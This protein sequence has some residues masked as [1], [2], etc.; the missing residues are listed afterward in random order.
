MHDLLFHLSLQDSPIKLRCSPLGQWHLRADATSRMP[1]LLP[2]HPLIGLLSPS[3]SGSA[4]TTAA[5]DDSS[6]DPHSGESE[7]LLASCRGRCSTVL[8]VP[9]G[10]VLTME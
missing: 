8:N 3:S 7:L 4:T 9:T 1:P 2:T 6:L 5:L 10:L